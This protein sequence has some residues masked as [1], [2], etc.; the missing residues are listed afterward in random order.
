MTNDPDIP[1]SPD[2]LPQQRIHEVVELPVRPAPFDCLVGYGCKVPQKALSDDEPTSPI[3][4]GQ[5]EWAWDPMH[6][7]LEAYYL[8]RDRAYWVLWARYWSDNEGE[9]GWVTVAC[10]AINGV[11]EEEAAVHLLIEFWKRETE[12]SSLNHFHW[13]NEDD[14]LSVAQLAAIGRAV[15]E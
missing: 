2:E 4:L 6:C 12:K 11:S 15:W 7:Q 1:M 9:G 10:V 13:I 8:Q 14:Y 3:Y 5:T